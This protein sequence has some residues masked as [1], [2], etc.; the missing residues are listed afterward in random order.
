MVVPNISSLRGCFLLGF[1]EQ[2]MLETTLFAI[3]MVLCSLTLLDNV[4]IIILA[5]LDPRLHTLMYI[6]LTQLSIMDLCYTSSTVPQLLVNLL[7]PEK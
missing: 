6:F 3:T 1:S 4:T 5:H 7:N 2:P